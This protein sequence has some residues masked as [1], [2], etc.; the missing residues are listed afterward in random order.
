MDQ[1]DFIMPSFKG[2]GPACLQEG[3]LQALGPPKHSEAL[4]PL[5]FSLLLYLCLTATPSPACA[6]N[7]MAVAYPSKKPFMLC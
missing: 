7:F 5:T 1:D 3:K 2:K 6:V 4:V